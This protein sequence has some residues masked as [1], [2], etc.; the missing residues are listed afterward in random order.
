MLKFGRGKSHKNK[1]FKLM[2]DT[3]KKQLK[4]KGLN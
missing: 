2:R 4:A 1:S 3:I